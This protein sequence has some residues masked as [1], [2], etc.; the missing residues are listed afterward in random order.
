MTSQ[1]DPKFDSSSDESS[2][3]PKPSRLWLKS[4][5]VLI[6]LGFGG[7]V[8]YGWYFFYYRLSP[9]VA[10]SL[11]SIL[12]RPIEMGELETFS[13]T[14]LRF[15]ETVVPP[16]EGYSEEVII[17]SVEVDFTPFK[18]ISEQTLELDVTLV[19]PDVKIEQTSEGEW[20]TTGIT[21]QP[22]GAIEIKLKTLAVENAKMSLSPRNQTGNFKPP[23][24]L[25]LPRLNSQFLDNNQ[26]IQFQVNDLSVANAQGSLSLEGE[27]RLESGE[28]N[29]AVTSN[30]LAIGEFAT[31]VASP[32][33]TLEGSLDAQTDI[34]LSLDGSLPTFEGSA[35]LNNLNAQIQQFN[36]PISDTNASM[37]L[38]GKD[39]IVE[40]FN[41][42][43]GEVNATAEGSINLAEGYDLIA[44]VK[45]TTISSLLDAVDVETPDIPL[46]GT[47]EAN[48]AI[49]GALDNP[50]INLTARSTETTQIDQLQIR[51]FQAALS[52]AGTEVI[53]ENFQATPE[54]G[55]E[56]IARGKLN[57]TPEQLIALDVQLRDVSGEMIRPYQSNLPPDLGTLNATATLTGSLQDWTNLQGEGNA[58]LAIAGGNVT[59]S[60]LDL[61][62]GFLQF[63]TK[64][65]NIQ[66]ENLSQQVPP[67]FQNPV[68]GE[69]RVNANLDDFSPEKLRLIGEG[70]LNIPQGEL[71][72]TT[73]TFSDRQLNANLNLT[74]IPIALLAP[75]TP[76]EFNELLSAT[77]RVSADVG[78]FNLNQIQGS[79]SGL[80][81]LG[82]RDRAQISLPNLSLNQGNWR[83][84]LTVNNFPIAQFLPQ[85][86]PQLQT[87]LINTQLTAQ[88]TLDNLTPAGV[89]V[90]GQARVEQLL[91]GNLNADT[92]RL[93]NGAF[94]VIASPNNLDL[95]QLSS[96]LNGNVAGNVS[97]KGNLD[98]LTPAGINAQANLNFNQGIAIITEPLTTNLRWDGQQI[99]LE[100]A[101]AEN[102]FARGTVALNLEKEGSEIIEQIDL[103]VDAQNLDLA[104]LPLPSPEPVGKIKVQGLA[105]FSGN[106]TGNLSQPQAQGDIRLQNF[107][108][109]RWS[110]DPEMTGEIQANASQGVRLEL[111]G[112]TNIPDRIQLA[113]QSPEENNILPLEPDS[114][115]IKRDEALIEGVTEAEDLQVSLQNLPLDLL[116]DFAPLNEEFARQ[117]ASGTLEGE[118]TV[119][120]ENFNAIGNLALVQPALGR[121]NSDRAAANFTY[122]DNT[123]TVQQATLIERESE[124]RANGRLTLTET[125]PNF[126]ANLDIKQGRIQDITSALQIFDLSDLNQNFVTPNYGNANNLNDVSS[127]NIENQPVET[128]L[129]RFSEIKALLQQLRENQ[130]TINPIPPLASAE[131]NFTG[132]VNLQG[133][134]FN[135]EDIQGEVQLNGDSWRWGP[136]QAQTVT[137][138]ANIT[139]GVITLLPIRLA[140]EDS[141][142]NLSGTFGGENQSA[143]LQVN[144]IPIAIIQNIIEVPEF[145][146]V[147]GFVNGT[148][149][150]AG[151]QENPTA[152]GELRVE[153]AILNETSVETIQGSFNYSNSQLN[154]FAEGLLSSDLNPLTISGDIP[155]KLPF[156][157]ILPPSE[158]LNIEVNLQDDGFTLVD[159]ISDGQLTWEGG[160]GAINLAITGPFNPENF[161]LDQLTTTGV[162]TLS[163]ASVATPLI[164]KPL[165]DIESRVEFNLNQLSIEE[166]N[167]DF[168]GGNVTATGG[169]ALFNSDLASEQININL[170]DLAVVIPN[171]Y[172][173]DVTGELIIGRTALEPEIGGDVTVS[174]GEVILAAEETATP[175]ESNAQGNN[176]GSNI[177]FSNLN[178]NLG[179]GV[180]VVRPPIMNFLASGRLTLKGTLAQMRPQGTISLER[181]RVNIGPTQFRLARGYEQTATFIPSQ[182]LDPTLNVRLVTSVAETSGTIGTS[183]DL[184]ATEQEEIGGGV[185]TLQSV[186]I[187]ALVQGRASELQPGQL[188]AN[189]NVLT[190]SSDPNRSE[191]EILALLGGGLTSGLGQGNTA[192]G[193]ANLAGSTFFG[194]FQNTIGDALGLSEFRIFPTFIP[195]ETE[196]GEESSGSTL[197]LGAEA[198]LEIS[199]DFSFSLLTI[200]NANQTFQYSIRY[201]LS[202]DLLLRGTTDLSDS[203]SVTVEYETRF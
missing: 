7:G 91:G 117:P 42:Q 87:V 3:P 77:F 152:R 30:Q 70:K 137:A 69:F 54:T 193:L 155:Y 124:Y 202:D 82:D 34:N 112:N 151:T 76:P 140:S 19:E 170:Q 173:G 194:T 145:I 71:V 73:I 14:S 148:A 114:F 169:L 48:I 50:Q 25:T 52:V 165:T 130:D 103:A 80:I 22:P 167:A 199:N 135:L 74:N 44:T 35:Q 75:Q 181:G 146:G 176:P 185:G 55:G 23:V 132:R 37:R 6:I 28:V 144:Q 88:G 36:T 110:F 153:E 101:E 83:S 32:V 188:T 171:L 98:N 102:L 10:K 106:L 17:P 195:T 45:P 184:A 11:S 62:Q 200:F 161:Q 116:K 136:Y 9:T 40:D 56:I 18:L 81:T 119:N 127:I 191:T 43:F 186:E 125:S 113:L 160:E 64:V 129:R 192:L 164:P 8:A 58:D 94:E 2:Q 131:G 177:G 90:Q 123:L 41:T 5:L 66:P 67:Q 143:Q 61:S 118:L 180:N 141:F 78:D 16:Q 120:L 196:E 154:F 92:I 100:Q 15:G 47:I 63:V 138:R 179:E 142:I 182:G 38:S 162:L 27:A 166:F 49:T 128:K 29:V 68:S 89:T 86:P 20:I 79:G 72:A 178:I 133:T 158:E 157:T 111:V 107:A 139:E 95:Q 31:L 46:S 99:I 126:E 197:G 189:D 105:N 121:F 85:L 21:E 187:E 159:V 109:E 156:A 93:E 168:G 13:L 172:D 26:R 104:E 174:D 33:E 53:V 4:L 57:L 201:R 183:T 51:S 65:R 24:N 149:T 163:Q 96:P 39:V 147:S 1:H 108:V 60:Q 203:Q 97:V 84:D 134:S 190:L 12:S 150:V 115:L 122:Q 59:I 175:P 198:G